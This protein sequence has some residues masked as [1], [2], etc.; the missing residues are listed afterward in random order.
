MSAASSVSSPIAARFG[1]GQSVSRIED[2]AL[3]AGAGRFAADV[4][5]PGQLHLCVLRS[6]YPHA[7]IAAIDASAALALPGVQAVLTG[8]D[9]LE[10]GLKPMA[11]QAVFLAPGGGRAPSTPRHT[12][13]VGH[14]RFVGEAVVAVLAESLDAARAGRDA[15]QVDYDDLPAVVD[16]A[17]ATA[18][19]APKVWADAADNFAAEMRHGDAAASDMAFASAAHVVALDLVNQRLAPAPLEPRALLGEYHAEGGRVTLRISS[20]MPG[21]V[22]DTLCNE[23]LGWPTDKLRVVVGDVGGGFGMKT[24]AYPEDI[25]VA[26][27]A[28][29]FKKPI[30]WVAER[31]DEFL[32]SSHGRDITSHAELALDADGKVLGLRVHSLANVGAYATTTGVIIQLLIGPWVGTSVYDIRTIDFRFKA[33]LTNTTPLG[34]YRGAGRPEAIYIIERLMDAAARELKLDPGELRRRNMI[35]PEQMPYT[36]AM[37]QVYD[38]GRFE[39][40]QTQALALAEWDGFDSRAAQSKQGGKLRGRG[41]A[42]FLEWT[43]GN[44]FEERVTVNVSGDGFIEIFSATQAMGQGIATSYA[45]LAVDVFGVPIEKVRIVQGDTDRGTGFGSAGSRSIFVGGSAVKV[46]SQRTVEK[47]QALAAEALEVAERDIEFAEGVFSVSGTDRRIGLFELAG[48]QPERQLFIDSTSSVQA[49]SWPNASHICEVEIDPDTGAVEVVSYASVNDVGRVISP[50]IVV[51]QVD[52]GAVQGLGQALCEQMVY[53]RESGQLQ[54]GSLM[55]YA[56]PRADMVKRFKTVLDQSTPCL[57]NPLG[58]KG[59]GELG[60]IGATP[61]VV[62]AVVDA[63]SRAGA[64]ERAAKLQMPLLPERVWRALHG[65]ASA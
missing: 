3:V 46:A 22:R 49:P 59:V 52:G 51:G 27:C 11:S 17:D 56:L 18:A 26:H 2:P 30:K 12:L 43:G 48:K 58:V 60:T 5:L 33:V 37:Q 1:S 55:D 24:G 13:A 45:Q 39:A 16:M 10:A 36:N 50:T 44:V 31:S 47:A 20:Q 15:V 41:I 8:A 19:G 6:P 61:A 28:D 38:S 21:G 23:V 62:N 63:L 7:R 35:R 54:T 4:S 9:L 53:E 29:K 14:V 42:T 64:G 32:G 65:T 57:T 25:L 40:V 34:A